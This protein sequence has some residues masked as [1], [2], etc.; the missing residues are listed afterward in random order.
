MFIT[1]ISEISEMNVCK[2]GVHKIE[3]ADRGPIYQRTGRIPIHYE[4]RIRKN[5][6][7]GIISRSTSA[8]C[9]RIVPV[10][11]P[12]GTLRMCIDYRPLNK[13][14]KKDIYPL[15][16]IDE[17]LDALA[18]SEYFT[19]LDATSGYYQIAVDKRDRVKTAFAW[20]ERL[21]ELNRMPFG[22]CNAPA[23][24][25][26]TMDKI[27][28]NERGICVLPYLDDIIIYSKSLEEHK[29]HLTTVVSKLKD[30]GVC[31]NRKKC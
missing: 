3:T 20:K 22:L 26:R 4:T 24:L 13:I 25:Q 15:P 12:D 31:L 30:A 14:T 28:G 23:I 27:L 11:K 29:L 5:L 10:T 17:I 8:W 19:S 1:E 6:Q 18:G 2:E 21:F 16:R 7:L 9:S